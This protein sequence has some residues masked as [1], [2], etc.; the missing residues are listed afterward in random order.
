MVVSAVR[1]A[2][3]AP[4]VTLVAAVLVRVLIADGICVVAAVA[5]MLVNV[6]LA[7]ES[8]DKWGGRLPNL[9]PRAIIIHG[10]LRLP[11]AHCR[12]VNDVR[13]E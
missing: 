13:I 2:V 10:T 7:L 4:P 12:L 8:L 5:A 11:L 6:L 1:V 3:D 9:P